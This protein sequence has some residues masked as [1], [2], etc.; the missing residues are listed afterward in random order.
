VRRQSGFNSP[1]LL[2][3]EDLEQLVEKMTQSASDGYP[4]YNVEHI[5]DQTLR[6]T[7]ALAGFTRADVDI[8][9]DGN[10]LVVKGKMPTTEGRVFLHQGIA[11]RQ[12]VR[13]FLLADGLD[14]DGAEMADGLLHID[15]CRPDPADRRRDIPIG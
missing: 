1:F 5:S 8:M 9:L 10:Q 14:V 6:I 12:F 2:G 11:A 13:R 15:L 4:P 7:I 3:F